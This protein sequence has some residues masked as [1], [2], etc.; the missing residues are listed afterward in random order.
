MAIDKDK[1][2]QTT[3]GTGS[4]TR[5]SGAG[6]SGLGTGGSGS[7]GTGGAGTTGSGSGSGGYGSTGG[8]HSGSGAAGSMYGESG[9]SGAG[10]TT[11]STYGAGQPYSGSSGTSGRYDDWNEEE[12]RWG[13]S[14]VGLY[15]AIAAGSIGALAYF[16]M[17]R[18]SA[19]QL[20]EEGT[21]R[22]RRGARNLGR[23]ASNLMERATSAAQQGAGR[24]AEMASE[25]RG[26]RGSM[27]SNMQARDVMT[28]SPI[29]CTPETT[30]EEVAEL[31]VDYD[32][33]AIPVVD[34][35]A[36]RR[37]VGMITDR[38]IVVRAIAK[39]KSTSDLT[40]NDVMTSD[41]I[42]VKPDD[43]LEDVIDR[44]QSKQVR[45]V[46]VCDRSG[47]IRGIISQADIASVAP[48]E[49]AGELV[50]EISEPG[51]SGSSTSRRS[52]D[53]DWLDD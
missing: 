38:D 2:D 9:S 47:K 1:T 19:S 15:S 24:F 8:G 3:K 34:S 25:R 29:L 26:R 4:S 5:G 21:R 53:E 10:P 17:N 36:N 43:L 22:A 12:S 14:R 44:M 39:G 6:S 31:M 30:L 48:S 20:L 28:D 35:K 37:P 11:S 51:G 41:V 16:L 32:T 23:G 45:R 27:A 49:H 7:T 13:G 46:L 52:R 50:A 40:V 33:G 42:A 18:E